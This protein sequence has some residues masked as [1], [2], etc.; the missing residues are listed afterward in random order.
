MGDL[1][2]EVYDL[3]V[4]NANPYGLNMV[5]F[6]GQEMGIFIWIGLYTIVYRVVFLH[7]VFFFAFCLS[8]EDLTK[9]FHGLICRLVY[10]MEFV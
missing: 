6:Y 1:N 9:C 5:G 8:G 2:F 10:L 4:F 7:K 3:W